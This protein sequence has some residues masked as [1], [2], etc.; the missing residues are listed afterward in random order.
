MHD[1]AKAYHQ[2]VTAFY[3]RRTDYDHEPGTTHPYKARRLLETVPLQ[4]GDRVLDV[5][6]GTGL[7]AI[8]A[9]EQ[10]G[11][12]GQVTG[13]DLTP[14]MLNQA[15]H[16]LAK[17]GLQNLELVKANAETIALPANRFDVL[18][19]CEAVV[20]FQDIPASFQKWHGWLKPGGYV[21]FTCPDQNAYLSEI[22]KQICVSLPEPM[23]HILEPL[24]TP[25][26]CHQLLEQARFGNIQVVV[27]QSGRDRTLADLQSLQLTQ[28]S[29]RLSFKGHPQLQAL[30][31]QQLEQMQATYLAAIVQKATNDRLW[32]ST[33]TFF[34]RAQKQPS[35]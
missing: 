5:A 26:R 21:A 13:I 11:P 14:G 23:G 19:C 6:T 8:A 24:G 35:P 16:K 2:A 20:L 10:V 25:Q 18:F 34:V 22:Y 7:V 9:A 33:T 15:R 29:L 31:P 32:E 1:Q 4:L 3:G 17:L 12:T 27:E 28:S 30:S